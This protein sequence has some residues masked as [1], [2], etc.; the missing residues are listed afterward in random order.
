MEADLPMGLC[1]D[2]YLKDDN[3][4][5]SCSQDSPELLGDL[6]RRGGPWWFPVVLVPAEQQRVTWLTSNEAN[7]KQRVT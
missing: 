1:I 3:K 4:S 2:F 7:V 6:I 5:Q